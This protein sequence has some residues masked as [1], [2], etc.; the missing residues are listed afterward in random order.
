MTK[1]IFGKIAQNFF[2]KKIKKRVMKNYL[3]MYPEE[4]AS[5]YNLAGSD[6]RKLINEVLQTT[7]QSYR[8]KVVYY[9]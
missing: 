5:Y 8:K 3:S 7:N 9:I 4:I 2:N 1:T 6:E